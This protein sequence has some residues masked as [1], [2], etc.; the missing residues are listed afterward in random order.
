MVFSSVTF[1]FLFL[2]AVFFLYHISPGIKI[3]NAV[4]IFASLLFYAWGEQL[5]VLLMLASVFIN[6]LFGLSIYR[7]EKYKK[8]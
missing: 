7:F 5:Y 2:P 1:L 3:K 6:W 8:I 4:L